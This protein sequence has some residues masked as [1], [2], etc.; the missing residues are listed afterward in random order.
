M[1]FRISRLQ[2]RKKLTCGGNSKRIRIR[3]GVWCGHW[4]T[5]FQHMYLIEEEWLLRDERG[6]LFLDKD[7]STPGGD[8]AEIFEMTTKWYKFC[9]QSCGRFG[10]TFYSG[11]IDIKLHYMLQIN[12]S[13][14]EC[15]KCHC[16]L[17]FK[18]HQS[19]YS[20]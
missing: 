18:N 8:A 16:C 12:H 5:E 1:T 3:S 10:E 14:K 13:W 9:W 15:S 17:I 20:L 2:W 6:K 11:E 19:H 7:E 4:I